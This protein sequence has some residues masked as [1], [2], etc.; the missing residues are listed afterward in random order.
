MGKEK[1]LDIQ[2]EVI[3]PLTLHGQG[4]ILVTF[5]NNVSFKIRKMQYIRIRFA[6]GEKRVE[7]QIHFNVSQYLMIKLI[8]T[9][10]D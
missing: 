7:Y 1:G 6:K 4:K 8:I 5:I 3:S 10:S 2:V 9:H